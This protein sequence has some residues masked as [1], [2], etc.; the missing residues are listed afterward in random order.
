MVQKNFQN[1]SAQR[2]ILFIA[3]QKFLKNDKAS[4]ENRETLSICTAT[5][6][7]IFL[8]YTVSWQANKC[9]I[10]ACLTKLHFLHNSIQLFQAK[11]AYVIEALF[12]L[13][14]RAALLFLFI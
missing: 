7:D 13:I 6:K 5:L 11:S 3:H 14:Q 12:I 2:I 10:L 1:L 4:G 8:T 9:S